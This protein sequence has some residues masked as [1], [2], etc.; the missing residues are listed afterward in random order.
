M[1]SANSGG[2]RATA[3]YV[4]SPNETLGDRMLLLIQLLAIKVGLEAPNNT[5]CCRGYRWL[6]TNW[7]QGL[8]AEDN[9]IQLV[10]H[11]EIEMVHTYSLYIPGY[12]SLFWKLFCNYQRGTVCISS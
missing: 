6:S 9:P 7:W 2:N 11:G 10:E 1:K 4:S 5:G 12:C 8:N 3:I